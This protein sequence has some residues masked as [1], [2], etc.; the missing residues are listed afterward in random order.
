MTPVVHIAPI[1]AL[2]AD[3]ARCAEVVAPP[4]DG[5]GVLGRRRYAA[6]HPDSFL[7][8]ILSR[9]DLPDGAGADLG[10]RARRTFEGMV[11]RGLY[12][13]ASAPALYLYELAADGH[14]QLGVIGAISTDLIAA[15]MILGHEA[16]LRS[17]TDE[18]SEFYRATRLSSSAVALT[19]FDDGAFERVIEEAAASGVPVRAF[20]SADG[21]TQRLWRLTSP[22]DLSAVDG[23]AA[24]LGQLY[25]TDGHHRVQAAAAGAT[26][27]S[28]LGVV[29]PPGQLRVLEYN[30]CVELDRP[31]DVRKL[32]AEL[33]EHWEVV[34]LGAA[35]AVDPRPPAVG[36]VGMLLG[37]RWYRLTA[38]D[39][40]IDPLAGLDVEMLHSRVIRPLFGV[41]DDGDRRLS[42]VVGAVDQ[43][44]ATCQTERQIGF[45]LHPTELDQLRRIADAGETM[46]PK[47]TYFTP[48]ARSGLVVVRW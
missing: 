3:P 34:E 31:V 17:R 23:A 25:I 38:R 13:P 47:S 24:A 42:F 10:E 15:G 40:P 33:D 12:E 35:G 41:A 7:N 19:Y 6:E 27:Q 18:L 11:D 36:I 44:E 48:K 30:R 28:F 22:A 14:R 43:L 32:F 9:I 21:T 8:V 5:L 45:A 4:Y 2:V 37:G 46:P 26:G 29:F 16:T 39:V 1:E 20:T